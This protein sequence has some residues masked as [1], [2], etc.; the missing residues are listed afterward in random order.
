MT[1]N[2][3]IEDIGYYNA[4]ATRRCYWCN[5]QLRNGMLYGQYWEFCPDCNVH[6]PDCDTDPIDMDD[7][8]YHKVLSYYYYNYFVSSRCWQVKE[9]W[10]KTV[11]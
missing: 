7:T 11:V 9:S 1:S 4:D 5:K 3:N 8:E 10:L 6:C 2:Q